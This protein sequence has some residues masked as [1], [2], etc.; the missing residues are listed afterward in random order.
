LS[1]IEKQKSFSID[2][3]RP[4]GYD[5]VGEARE[6]RVLAT[7]LVSFGATQ[8]RTTSR[9][10]GFTLVELLVVISIVAL[11]VAI[12]LPALGKAR[13][14]A[15]MTK[16]SSNLRQVGLLEH[17]YANDYDG[18]IPGWRVSWYLLV[19]EYSTFENFGRMANELNCPDRDVFNYGITVDS[20]SYA[21]LWEPKRG[22]P[23]QTMIHADGSSAGRTIYNTGVTPPSSDMY[24]GHL[25]KFTVLLWGDSHVNTAETDD[26]PAWRNKET[27]WLPGGAF[28]TY[29]YAQF[30]R[31]TSGGY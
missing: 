22:L 20:Q 30:W 5:S 31:G 2:S 7:S 4:G 15:N 26:I 8:M 6:A 13:G 19:A 16:C 27:N 9:V 29:R 17:N 23:S 3:V 28:A 11:L 18:L 1:I 12:L 14:V 24:F 25:D 10:G 21:N